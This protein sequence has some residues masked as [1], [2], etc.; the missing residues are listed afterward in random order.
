[1]LK[2]SSAVKSISIKREFVLTL[3]YFH[4]LMICIPY[5]L[6]NDLIETLSF[7]LNEIHG[8][9]SVSFCLERERGMSLDIV[10]PTSELITYHRHTVLQILKLV[11]TGWNLW[12]EWMVTGKVDFSRISVTIQLPFSRLNGRHISVTFQSA[13]FLKNKIAPDADWTRDVRIKWK[14]R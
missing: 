1:M 8:L 6:S 13:Y 12:T 3:K 10:E 14:A 7:H 5:N 11:T 2:K 4:F 9:I